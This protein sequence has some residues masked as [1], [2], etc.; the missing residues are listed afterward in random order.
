MLVFDLETNGF[1]DNVTEIHCG[2]TYN[3]D[4][5]V[6]KSYRPDEISMLIKDLQ[7]SD[8]I[9][10]H[11]GI[12]YDVPVIE[13]L[14]GIDLHKTCKVLD[15]MIMSRIAYYNLLKLDE[16]NKTLLRLRLTGSH[17]LKAWGIRLGELKGAY[18]EQEC[19]WDVFSEDMLK[20]CEQDVKVTVKLLEKLESKNVPDSA[21][22]VEHDFARIIQRQVNYGWLFDVDKAQKLHVTLLAE[23]DKLTKQLTE[24][25]KPIQDWI[26]MKRVVR[27]TKKGD[28][29]KVYLNQVSKGAHEND[30]GEWGRYEELAFNP[31]SR[32]H[33]DRWMREVYGWESPE[34]TEKGNPVINDETLKGAEFPEAQLLR[35]YFLINKVIGMVAEGKNAWL[36]VVGRDN[37]IHGQVNTLGAVTGR[38]THNRP[39]V[40]QTPSSRAFMGKECR[41]LFTVPSGKKIIG[42]DASGLELRMLAH[43]MANYDG[44][45]YGE[46]VVNGDIHSINQE[47]AG[48]P[49][50]DNAKTFIYGFLYGAGNEKIGS[51]V[52]GSQKIGKKLKATF[53]KKIPALAKLTEAVKKSAGKGFLV[54]LSKR[55]YMIKSD[56]AALNVLLQGAGAL[57][58]KYYLVELDK[59][60]HSL[61][62]TPG[63]EYEFIGNIHDEVQIEVDENVVDKVSATA[64][65]TFGV[66]EKLLNFRVKLDGEAKVGDTWYDTH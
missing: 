42:C 2:V 26:P 12:G 4:T 44:G 19:A 15:T 29:S 27:Y 31:A 16:T 65:S 39:N 30:K 18:G 10:A 9:V 5:K 24:T 57:V 1:L 60:L 45:E 56:H 49:T 36:K 63:K 40:A 52:G 8:T 22:E 51:I 59:A 43:Y 41:Q 33:I 50:R 20:Y 62:L 21:Y 64:E 11:N 28:E 17:G 58:M 53:L 66:V 6:Y 23:K 61:G 38:C 32:H 35:E 47:A 13:K 14:Y 55:K 37:R 54:G 48:L 34:K 25:F 46:Q 7:E 3:T